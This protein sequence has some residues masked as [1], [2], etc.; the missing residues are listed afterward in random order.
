MSV[1]SLLTAGGSAKDGIM[2]VDSE[3]EGELVLVYFSK[4][5]ARELLARYDGANDDESREWMAGSRAA[6]ESSTS[7]ETAAEPPITVRGSAA[8]TIAEALRVLQR[9]ASQVPHQP[10]R[11]ADW[12]VQIPSTKQQALEEP[13]G[14]FALQRNDKFHV[15]VVYS[16]EQA[17]ELVERHMR[18][19]S[20]SLGYYRKLVRSSLW[21]EKAATAPIHIEGAAAQSISAALWLRSH[22]YE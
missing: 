11:W 9:M 16:K 5:Q 8:G 13:D 20:R 19:D 10:P 21:P 15:H 14:I 3:E 22:G 1:N 17:R 12:S 4:A 18:G 6:L 7:P 2:V